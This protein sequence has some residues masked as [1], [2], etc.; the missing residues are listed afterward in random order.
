MSN[1]SRLAHLFALGSAALAVLLSS[2]CTTP[3][4][5]PA[6]L[7]HVRLHGVD[8]PVVRIEKIWLE[9]KNDQLAVRGYVI[10]RLEATDTTRTHLDVTLYDAGGR[11]LRTSRET[12]SPKQIVRR[13]RRPDYASYRVVL[14]P[15][16]RGVARIEV[17]ADETEHP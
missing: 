16:P 4:R 12:F 9:R 13:H 15:L 11:V 7:A 8:S 6:D 10:R 14:D 1:H 2:G 17:R 3:F 5:P